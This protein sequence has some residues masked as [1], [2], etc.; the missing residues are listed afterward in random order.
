MN[1][2]PVLLVHGLTDT[3]RKMRHIAS[4]L[5]GLGWEVHDIDLTPSNGDETL[6][7]LAAQVAAK[8][9]RTHAPS[10][11]FDLIGFSMGGLVARYYIQSLGG[12]NRVQR[13]ITISTPHQG[14][15]AAYFSLRPGCVQMRPDSDFM[16]KLNQDLSSLKQ[17]NFTSL[18]TPFD[19]IILPPT[20]SE[21]GIGTEF[22]FPVIAHPLMVRDSHCLS[23]ISTALNQPV[24]SPIRVNSCA[25]K[26][27][28]G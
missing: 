9:D 17:L 4:H 10:Q 21:L 13:F 24:A 3:S 20:S 19:L 1:R 25:P 18:W 27:A 22:S 16:T 23:A 11:P 15:L 5:R 8:I 28:S 26:I 12:I 7:V 2:N 6:E 14:T